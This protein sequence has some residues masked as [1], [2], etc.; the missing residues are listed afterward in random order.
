MPYGLANLGNTC[1]INSTLQ[2]L[3][4]IPELRKAIEERKS[5]ESIGESSSLVK[6]LANVFRQL[7][8]SGDTVKPMSFIQVS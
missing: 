7:E 6:A 5:M 8:V 4:K 1:Y 3:L 2:V